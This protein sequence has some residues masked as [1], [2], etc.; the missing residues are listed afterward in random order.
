LRAHFRLVP[1]LW[2]FPGCALE[3]FGLARREHKVVFQSQSSSLV[4]G[5]CGPP[6]MGLLQACKVFLV[7]KLVSNNRRIQERE[8]HGARR[9]DMFLLDID[10]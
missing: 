4:L 6:R 2:R 8:V 3:T 1:E 7:G 9:A 5:A 10:Y